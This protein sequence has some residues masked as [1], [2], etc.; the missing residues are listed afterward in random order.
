[1]HFASEDAGNRLRSSSICPTD[2]ADK[3]HLVDWNY[4]PISEESANKNFSLN[5]VIG[6][7][8]VW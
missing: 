1:M 5:N 7:V 8:E 6:V 2:A 4:A 3:W